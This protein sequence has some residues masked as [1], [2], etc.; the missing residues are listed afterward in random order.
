VKQCG[1]RVAGVIKNIA[2][3][4]IVL[5]QIHLIG[6]MLKKCMVCLSLIDDELFDNAIRLTNDFQH[7][8]DELFDTKHSVLKGIIFYM[9]HLPTSQ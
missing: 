7:L 6:I 3:N 2:N 8:I 4:S 9:D 5:E 1:V